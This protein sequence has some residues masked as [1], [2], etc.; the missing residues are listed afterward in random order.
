MRGFAVT[1]PGLEELTRREFTALG[2]EAGSEPGGVQFEGEAE[3][4]YRANLHLRTASRV[5]VRA[6]S[7]QAR[8]F[9][10]LERHARRIDWKAFLTRGS[11]FQLRVSSRKSKLY[12]ERAI[13]ERFGRWIQED[14]GAVLVT[15]ESSSS[16]D[17]DEGDAEEG[18][19]GAQSFIIRF[20]RD[21]C[22][23][24]ADSSGELLHRRGYRQAV[25][26][27]PLRETL[28]A[29]ML[30]GSGWHGDEPLLD[31]LCGSGTIPIEAA[32]IGRGIPPGLSSG[33][34]VPRSYAFEGWP[35][36]DSEVWRRVVEEAAKGILPEAPAP[37]VG[38][39]R[40]H[41]AVEAAAANAGRAGVA[42]DVAFDVLPIS[43][44]RG[45]GS[46]GLVATNPPY[47]V[48]VGETRELRDLYAAFGNLLRD[49]LPGWRAAMLAADQGLVAQTGLPAREILR[50]RNGGI[51]VQLVALG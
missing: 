9:I 42:G 18:S 45:R 44:S 3:T 11:T 31:P 46:S 50:T 23:V 16:S 2:I 15:S 12:H 17:E 22:L 19:S 30:L 10:E 32:L 29:A 37:I 5:L 20:H 13:A 40:D 21:Q 28:G 27:A 49:K 47:G 36:F 51:P 39:D 6:A 14:V 35:G 41:G 25:A 34:R 33:D 7:F 1:A 48:R 4:I 8:S 24:S 43:A 38:T 26:K